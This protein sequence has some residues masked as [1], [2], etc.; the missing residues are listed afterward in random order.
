[1]YAYVYVLPYSQPVAQMCRFH[2]SDPSLD[3]KI[4]AAWL[5]W[6]SGVTSAPSSRLPISRDAM[7][8]PTLPVLPSYAN[9]CVEDITCVLHIILI[10]LT[11]QS[12]LSS[13]WNSSQVIEIVNTSWAYTFVN[14]AHRSHN[15]AEKVD[16][17]FY[18]QHCTKTS[19]K[20]TK[21]IHFFFKYKTCHSF[22]TTS[23][24]FKIDSNESCILGRVQTE[25]LAYMFLVED[26]C[27]CD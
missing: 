10:Q 13:S 11:Q 17:I 27:T 16:I 8:V 21:S 12:R 14:N 25:T 26:V 4:L 20:N 9:Q 24:G 1:M 15:V 6:T 5:G 19:S 22:T 2:C 3:E 7:G 18:T 23:K